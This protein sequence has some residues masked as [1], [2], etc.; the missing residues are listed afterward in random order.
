MAEKTL[1]KFVFLWT[2]AFL[3]GVAL[4]I[5]LYLAVLARRVALRGA[6]LSVVRTPSAAA[7]GGELLVFFFLGLLDSIHYRPLL[8]A[9]HQAQQT[10]HYAPLVRSALDEVLGWV[11]LADK[12]RRYSTT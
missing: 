9:R 1:P 11:G 6:W 2:D 3:W 10:Q 12:E 7:A 4:A 8:P 5:V